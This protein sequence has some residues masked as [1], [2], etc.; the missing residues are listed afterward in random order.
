MPL[1]IHQVTNH[2]SAILYHLGVSI[3]FKWTSSKGLWACR[4]HLTMRLIFFMETFDCLHVTDLVGVHVYPGP[5]SVSQ[6][7]SGSR[8]S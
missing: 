3:S 1:E 4:C 5:V 6:L 7:F 2:P 8:V